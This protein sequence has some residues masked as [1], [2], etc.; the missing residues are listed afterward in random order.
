[1]A[2]LVAVAGFTV[3]MPFTPFY[4]Q[5]LGVTDPAQV[6]LWSGLVFSVQAVT[7]AVIAPVWGTLADRYGRKMMVERAMF[8]GVLVVG[9]MGFAGNVYQLL[10]LRGLQGFVTGTVPAATT[11]VASSV[12]RERTGSALGLLQMAVWTG[13]SAGPLLGGVVADTFGY[14]VTFWVTASLLLVA[15]LAVHFLVHEEFEPQTDSPGQQGRL[16]DGVVEVIRSKPLLVAFGVQL[17]ARSS[18]RVT[19]PVLPLFVQTLVLDQSRIASITGLVSGIGAA[20]GA[21]ASVVL[22]RVSDRVGNRSVLLI[23]GLAAAF[24]YL[25][26]SPATSVGQVM[27]LQGLAGGAMGG[28]L[29]LL[30]ATLARSAPHGRYGAVYGVNTSVISVANA[31]GPMLGA[32]LAVWAGLRAT[33]LLAAALFLLASLMVAWLIPRP[34]L[35][36]A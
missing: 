21:I 6:K 5:D 7:M 14:R 29:V 32:G 1:M 35:K 18:F 9:A 34:V 3:F 26:Y 10:I 8:G 12:P 15:G 28:M 31:V 20:S 22:G 13:A 36:P 4:I 19:G 11:L 24:F 17:L 16:R 25:P 30:S 2:E 23:C 33:F 27:L